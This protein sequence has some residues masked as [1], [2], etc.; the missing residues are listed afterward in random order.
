MQPVEDKFYV[1]GQLSEYRKRNP[2]N[3]VNMQ[4]ILYNKQGQSLIG[5]TKTDKDGN[6]V[7]GLP[8]L[9]GEWK[10]FFYS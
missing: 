2:V 6:Y 5:N 4:V 7:F 8:F 9:N 3:D 1:F 10:M